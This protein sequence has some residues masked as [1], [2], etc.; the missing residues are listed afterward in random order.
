MQLPS[1]HTCF[2]LCEGGAQRLASLM[3][4]SD[5]PNAHQGLRTTTSGPFPYPSSKHPKV[6]FSNFTSEASDLLPCPSLGFAT[7]T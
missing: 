7:N 4:S 3:N 5:D 2:R 1:P 6:P